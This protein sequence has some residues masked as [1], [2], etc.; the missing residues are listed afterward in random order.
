MNILPKYLGIAG[1]QKGGLLAAIDYAF[2]YFVVVECFGNSGVPFVETFGILL[3]F[4]YPWWRNGEK[5]RKTS[6]AAFFG[7]LSESCC[8]V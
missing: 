6:W 8:I 7:S 2:S 3:Y 1:S 4:A 5:A